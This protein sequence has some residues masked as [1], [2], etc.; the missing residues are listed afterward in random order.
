[1]TDFNK[2]NRKHL[3]Q[4]RQA[5]NKSDRFQIYLRTTPPQEWNCNISASHWKARSLQVHSRLVRKDSSFFFKIH[6]VGW[7]WVHLVCRPLTGSLYQPR[8]IVEY[9]LVEWDLATE[10]L[11]RKL[12][13]SQSKHSKTT[14]QSRGGRKWRFRKHQQDLVSVSST[15]SHATLM[16]YSTY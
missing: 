15:A 7:D 13:Q 5:V 6:E 4:P 10:V 14:W 3:I 11:L 2:M 8:M 9:N 16:F 12:P 1:M